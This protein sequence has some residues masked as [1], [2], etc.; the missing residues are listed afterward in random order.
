MTTTY[1][2]PEPTAV[3]GFTD[4]QGKFY[5]SR[6]AAIWADFNR[7]LRKLWDEC[8]DMD[9]D[10]PDALWHIAEHRPDMLRILLGD[11]DAT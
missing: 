7:D 6:E 11:R 1:V 5:F 10:G 9:L 4:S 8:K 3:S 2:A